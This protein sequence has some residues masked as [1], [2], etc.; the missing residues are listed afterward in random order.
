[1]KKLKYFIFSLICIISCNIV[2]AENEVIIKSITPVYDEES[3]ILVSEE[4]NL[5]SVTFN[6]KNQKVEYK[7]I[8]ENTT[9]GDV[10]IT[11]INL[12]TPTEEFLNYDISGILKDD[13][14]SA[15][16]TKEFIVSLETVQMDGWGRNFNDELLTSIE[17]ANYITNSD[18]IDFIA[19]PDTID[20]IVC[21]V[22]LAVI[23]ALVLYINKKYKLGKY[24]VLVIGL[25]SLLPM[26]KAKDSITLGLKINASFESQ[27]IMETRFEE[28]KIIN[29]GYGSSYLGGRDYW[30]YDKYIKNIYI[31]NEFNEIKDYVYK[32]DISESKNEKV[33]AY[34]V[35]N[36]ENNKYYDLYLQ[37]DGIIYANQD[38]RGYFAA[39]QNLDN[40]DNLTGLDTSNV[41]NMSAMF[42][43]TG[44]YS[45]VFALD[46]S[47]FNTSK[48]LSMDGMFNYTGYNNSNFT[49]DL[50]NFDTSNVTNMSYMFWGTG[51]YNSNFTLDLSSFNT[52]NVTDMSYMFFETGSSSRN[53]T[54][55]LS[56]FDTSN[57]TD[58]SY[59]FY[60][61]G[62]D[63]FNFTLDLSNFDTSNVTDMSSMFHSTGYNSTNFNLDLSNFDTSNVTNMSYMFVETGYNNSNF[64]LDVS[65]FDTSNVTDMS[66]M[67]YATGYNSTKVNTSI[68]LRNPFLNKYDRMFYDTATGAGS[69]IMINYTSATKY[70]VS[71]LIGTTSSRSNVIIGVEVD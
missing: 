3:T 43:N 42:F 16:E 40:I 33:I 70:L 66:Y 38:S 65:N 50:S 69:Q 51:Y 34:L 71:N 7:V 25:V 47:G 20:F 32:Y 48:A 13:V 56:N 22:G 24:I 26:A 18:T 59:M 1:M 30:E 62:V 21:I 15:N 61:T 49:L 53:F 58:M 10:S 28:P 2:F 41:T 68:T 23:S 29:L 55:D 54:L 46:L 11:D 6:D 37:A 44:Y 36:E 5:H 60:A 17:F 27:N 45:D 14:L 57:V 63:S 19:N 67:F 52:S 12:S 9:D 64:T 8:I 4:D 39:M 31:Q 35:E